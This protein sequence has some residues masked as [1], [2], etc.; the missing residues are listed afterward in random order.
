MNTHIERKIK[1]QVTFT[2]HETF[3]IIQ[4]GC[5]KIVMVRS[6]NSIYY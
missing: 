4:V 1:K 2:L 5:S 6:E 3:Y